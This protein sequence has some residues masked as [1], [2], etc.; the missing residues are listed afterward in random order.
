MQLNKGGIMKN[1]IQKL[2][3]LFLMMYSLST[4]VIFGAPV[5][6]ASDG[7]I[8]ETPTGDIYT[9]QEVLDQAT[10]EKDREELSSLLEDVPDNE[11]IYNVDILDMHGL[12]DVD[13]LDEQNLLYFEDI[14]V[15][16]A[17][18]YDD[19]IVDDVLVEV[20]HGEVNGIMYSV[21]DETAGIIVSFND[22]RVPIIRSA[23]IDTMAIEKNSRSY[24]WNY[25]YKRYVTNTSWQKVTGTIGLALSIGSF[26]PGVGTIVGIAGAA[27]GGI[28]TIG[29]LIQ[30]QKWGITY[31][32]VRS[33]RN[34]RYRYRTV[35]YKHSNYSGLL[36]YGA[37]GEFATV[38]GC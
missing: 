32:Y 16:F 13:E 27:I 34:C 15:D 28:T 19:Y 31:Y 29:S 22:V 26:I 35:W 33:D 1:K 23:S 4:F 3:L 20:F 37:W 36:Y 10:N 12:T 24:T 38:R 14:I 18:Y 9:E 6:S 5:L 8:L 30:T 2:A 11:I 7:N 21:Y 17:N 25:S